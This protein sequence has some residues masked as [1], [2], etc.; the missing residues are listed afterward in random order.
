MKKFRKALETAKKNYLA[1]ERKKKNYFL[2]SE[3]TLKSP[4]SYQQ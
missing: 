2:S 3:S 1:N 4:N